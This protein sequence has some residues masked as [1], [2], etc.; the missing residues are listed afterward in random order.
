[1]DGLVRPSRSKIT[2][3]G[4]GAAAAR[5][6]RKR[7]AL[8]LRPLILAAALTT[9]LFLAGGDRFL[10][11]S[12]VMAQEGAVI[13]ETAAPPQ[14]PFQLPF[15]RPSGPDTWLMAQP[16]G[17]TT[18]A[19]RQRFTTYGAS[20]G[21]HFGVDLSAAC[22]TEIVAMADGV[23][24]AVDGP[25][26]SPPHNLML[27]HPQVGY[28][29]MYGHL[30]QAPSLKPGDV[31]KQGQVVALSGDPGETCYNRPH[32]HLEIRDLNHVTKYNPLLLIEANWQN[33]ALTGASAR[34]FA[35]DLEEPR[36]WQSLYDQPE[37][38]TGGPIVN[39][40]AYPWPFDWRNR[41]ATSLLPAGSLNASPGAPAPD[42]ASLSTLPGGRQ[43]T[44]GD[45]CTQPYWN[46][47]STQVRFIDQPGPAVPLGIWAVELNQAEAG[48][49]FVTGQLG[50]YSPNN[51]YVAYPDPITGQAVV[52]RL[53]DGQKWEFD[54]QKHSLNFSP[55]SRHVLWTVSGED[56][57][58]DNQPEV[59]WVANVDGS[60]ARILLRSRRIDPVAWLPEGEL[61]LAQRI[62]GGSDEQLFKLSI[63][64]GS[65]TELLQVPRMRGLALSPDR[66][67]L[68]YYVSLQAETGKNGTWLLDLQHPQ[69]EPQKLPFFGT[70][71]W[72]DNE[73]LIYVPFDPGAIEHNF[74]EY[75]ILTGQTQS[76]FP[77]GTKLTIANN[78]W[79]VSPDGSKIVLVAAQGAELDG[80]WVLE[81]DKNL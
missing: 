38:R 37:V 29:S 24:F 34:N 51:A 60:D 41:N 45:C 53:A 72:R 26:G 50:N 36:K 55:D 14:P 27:D 47:A 20:G 4:V 30:L 64:T 35:R 11:V 23:V 80:I 54:T 61:L 33:L 69:Q 17:N 70:Y 52:E 25:F 63:A 73:R 46:N 49:E 57:F 79:R 19:Y 3:G 65:Q 62:P 10:A 32:L 16:Y 9:A 2:R 31:V 44:A 8:P 74:Y 12:P 77:S 6:S 68:V 5:A 42:P 39:D 15:A 40:F 18:G 81:L 43:M 7:P 78:D 67:Y 56:T 58:N 1:M 13:Q 66:R 28:A 59:I 71:R 22:G 75:D 76:L 21:I 48:P